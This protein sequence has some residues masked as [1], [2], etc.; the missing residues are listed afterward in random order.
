MPSIA[1]NIFAFTRRGA[2]HD[3]TLTQAYVWG[4]QVEVGSFATSYIPTTDSAVTRAA[5][6]AEISGTNF[7]SWYNPDAS[8][9][10][11]EG[12]VTAGP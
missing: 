5:D 10:Y 8:T 11:W 4:C 1:N 3:E 6:L 2:T 12:N 7:S 9:V